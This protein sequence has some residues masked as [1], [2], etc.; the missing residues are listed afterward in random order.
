[1]SAVD[2]TMS[3]KRQVTSRRSAWASVT[4]GD[5]GPAVHDKQALTSLRSC[6]AH[7]TGRPH[8]TAVG[9]LWLDGKIY[10]TTGAGTRKRRNLTENAN[11]VI[12][13]SLKGL[14]LVATAEPNGAT[15][16][17]AGS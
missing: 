12:S 11:C 15:P 7:V 3:M 17:A 2:A 10:F 5:T 8:L 9:A 14:D 1:M 6:S 16:F 13:I 4:S